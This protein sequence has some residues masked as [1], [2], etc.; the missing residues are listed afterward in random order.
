MV[1][2]VSSSANS[3]QFSLSGYSGYVVDTMA[4]S[5]MFL[6]FYCSFFV[7]ILFLAPFL[8]LF[9]TSAMLSFDTA[10]CL[11]KNLMAFY[12]VWLKE[13]IKFLDFLLRLCNRAALLR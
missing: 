6:V 1:R 7:K 3:C 13:I 8:R 11:Q 10:Q 4:L 9:F 2:I 5:L 12:L